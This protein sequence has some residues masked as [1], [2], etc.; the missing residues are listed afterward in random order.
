LS[1]PVAVLHRD[2]RAAA[3]GRN[4][5]QLDLGQEIRVVAPLRA[6]L[7]AEQQARGRLPGQHLAPLR[8]V[9]LGIALEPAAVR[10][11][12]DDDGDMGVL[13]DGLALGPPIA[14]A[15]REELEGARGRRLDLNLMHD[16]CYAHSGVS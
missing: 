4:E 10:P 16:G 7:P 3:L 6:D 13:A 11:G 5:G 15:G 1:L 8:L 9:A 2:Q 14:E 12:L